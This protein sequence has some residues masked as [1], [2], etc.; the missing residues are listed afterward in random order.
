MVWTDAVQMIILLV[1][2]I[3]IA[4]LGSSEQGGAKAVWDVAVSTGRVNYNRW[5]F[6]TLIS[7]IISEMKVGYVRVGRRRH[8]MSPAAIYVE[9]N[10]GR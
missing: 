9:R 4:A 1:G 7:N 8:R 10:P 3:V 2:L 6:A 5:A